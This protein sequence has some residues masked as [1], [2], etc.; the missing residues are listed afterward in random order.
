MTERDLKHIVGKQNPG[1]GA[2]D[3]EVNTAIGGAGGRGG[4]PGGRRARERMPNPHRA[5]NSESDDHRCRSATNGN[6][7]EEEEGSFW[8]GGQ[9]HTLHISLHLP[10]SSCISCI[11]L[12][13]LIS[14]LS[15]YLPV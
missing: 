8:A 5:E 6:K 14:L 3:V 2:Y 1:V 4:G 15:W 13:S 9:H 10:V 7:E 12:F 11:S